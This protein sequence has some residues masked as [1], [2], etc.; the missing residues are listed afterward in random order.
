MKLIPASIQRLP[1][2]TK[3]SK[4]KRNKDKQSEGR[5]RGKALSVSVFVRYRLRWIEGATLK[6]TRMSWDVRGS[7]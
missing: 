5:R 2:S 1:F 3:L 6:S 7:V 4:K